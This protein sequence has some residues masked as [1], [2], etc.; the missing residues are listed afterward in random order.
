MP[1]VPVAAKDAPAGTVEFYDNVLPSLAAGDYLIAVTQQVLGQ[2]VDVSFR[3]DQPMR[4]SGP[5]FGLAPGDVCAAYPPA[6]GTADYSENLAAVVLGRRDLPWAIQVDGAGAGDGPGEPGGPAVM[7]WLAVLLLCP[8]EIVTAAAANPTPTGAHTVPLA[9]Y[10]DPPAGTLGPAF[11]PRQREE[12]IKENPAD[13]TLSVVDVTAEAFGSVAPRSAELTYLAHARR[14]D[15]EDQEAVG[16]DADGW[17]SIVIGNRLA[18]GSPTG[19]YAAHLVSV[20]GF[21]S[22]LPPAALASGVATVRLVSLASWTF[23]S[24]PQAGDFAGLMGALDVGLL[25]L[26]DLVPGNTAAPGPAPGLPSGPPPSPREQVAKALGEGYTALGYQTR[27]GELTTGWY[28]GGCLPVP[29]AHNPQPPYPAAEAAL[30][31]D[32]TTGMF[33]VSYAVAWQTGRLSMLANRQIVISLLHWLRAN[34]RICQLLLERLALARSH[35]LL[36]FPGDV[37]ALLAP[38][39][40]RT[41][42]RGHLAGDLA[43]RLAPPAGPERPLLGPPRDPTGLLRHLGRLP[44]LLAPH[45]VAALAADGGDPTLALVARVRGHP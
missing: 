7:P 9:D 29:V 21:V 4:V 36:G 2:G 41:L 33:D 26:P 28:R 12:F 5:H 13:F 3:H 17:V 27:L 39:L 32:Q 11:S 25:R 44:G 40:L 6:G 37:G 18:Q 10:L 20:E 14:V 45:E 24:I 35:D 38:H 19:V 23:N 16:G 42:T 8:G 34:H 43:P 31:Y 22:Q 15:A 1:A 30:I